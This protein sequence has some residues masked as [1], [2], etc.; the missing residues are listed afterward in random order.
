[1]KQSMVELKRRIDTRDGMITRINRQFSEEKATYTASLEAIEA[2]R[3]L[4]VNTMSDLVAHVEAIKVVFSR[5]GIWC[6]F[7]RAFGKHFQ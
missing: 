1:M 6:E 3:A 7:R 5:I 2:K 4:E